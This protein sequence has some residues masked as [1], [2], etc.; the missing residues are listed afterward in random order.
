MPSLTTTSSSTPSPSATMS[1]GSLAI[2]GTPIG[3]YGK[4]IQPENIDQL[5]EIARW[6]KGK[7]RDAAFSPDGKSFA[8]ASWNGVY[9]YN[10][11]TYEQI[12]W[13][14]TEAY[15]EAVTY[16]ADGKIL[17]AGYEEYHVKMWVING[18]II[19][20]ELFQSYDEITCMKFSRNGDY[21]AISMHS[22]TIRIW[23]TLSGEELPALTDIPDM[24]WVTKIDFSPDG[25]YL[26]ADISLY[27]DVTPWR[28]RIKIFDLETGTGIRELIGHTDPVSGIAFSPDGKGLASA[29][30][31]GTIR[32][33]SLVT[34]REIKK[35]IALPIRIYSIVFSP[36]GETISA[37]L[38]DQSVRM[39]GVKTG[40]LIRAF[41][42]QA[43][44][45]NRIIPSSDGELL[46]TISEE[47]IVKI[48]EL[49][50]G[51]EK[52]SLGGYMGPTGSVAFSPN[53]SMLASGSEFGLTT[54]WDTSNGSEIRRFIQ[55][56]K[57][58]NIFPVQ[59]SPDGR[60]L[61]GYS[62]NQ[63]R[64]WDPMGKLG[65]RK[66]VSRFGRI[67]EIAFSADGTAIA[68][69]V[70]T[71]EW[72]AAIEL[73]NLSTFTLIRSFPVSESA[74]VSKIV[75]S[76]N[77][78]QISA[79]I[80]DIDR[81]KENRVVGW[82]WK[83]GKALPELMNSI[84]KDF[85]DIIYSEDGRFLIGVRDGRITYWDVSTGEEIRTLN[86]FDGIRSLHYA[87]DKKIL[88][89]TIGE[90]AYYELAFWD[91]ETGK[92]IYRLNRSGKLVTEFWGFVF[93]PDGKW[94][95]TGMYNGTISLWGIPA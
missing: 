7:P 20:Q 53:G 68:T 72:K 62:G 93:S 23:D 49:S 48:L 66:L 69:G 31:D 78:K 42:G 56:T 22:S 87:P 86:G 43:G 92:E 4:N 25:K 46:L 32:L 2:D 50:T 40:T 71:S 82:E 51:N 30:L 37:G 8:V 60:Y 18:E 65:L 5:V 88:V 17:A 29:S 34:G 77:G 63:V 91:A 21:L 84:Q 39:W 13:I 55:E 6:G 67:D 3:L 26:A 73:W 52:T 76:P 59:F 64:F 75:F 83:T 47:S 1:L 70:G 38:E 19:V 85:T 45:I 14:N 9:I 95:A 61:V 90:G 79:I 41:H 12:R 89:S 94:L 10:T 57:Y 24:N 81:Y 35:L 80:E 44:K 74:Y 58:N 15:M 54:I 36:D 11:V 33:W 16:T 27:A 28:Y